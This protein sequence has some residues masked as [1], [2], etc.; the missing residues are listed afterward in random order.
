MSKVIQLTQGMQTVVDD[1]DHEH[2]SRHRWYYNNK[3]GHGYALRM[4][5]RQSI[6]LHREIMKPG[7]GFVV[8]HINGNTLDNRRENL[9]VVSRSVNSANTKLPSN[10][11]SGRRGVIWNK[12][13][14]KWQAQF[15]REGKT[16]YLGMFDD[17]DLAAAAYS[18]AVAIHFPGEAMSNRSV[19]P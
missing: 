5:G 10:N 17:I 6:L 12:A 2:L 18:E 11:T 3:G 14:K 4:V 1:G 19:R 13:S 8:D 15:T 7:T 9:R 16:V